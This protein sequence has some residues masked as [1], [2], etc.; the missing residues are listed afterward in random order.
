MFAKVALQFVALSSLLIEVI[1]TPVL[2]GRGS[3]NGLTRCGNSI[4]FNHWGGHASLDNLDHFYGV[5]NFDGLVH[6]SQVVEQE[7]Q[8]IC[9]TQVIEIIQQC[10]VVLQEMAKRIITEQIC[11]VR[12]QTIGMA[13]AAVASAAP[14]IMPIPDTAGAGVVGVTI[15][16]DA[17]D[18]ASGD[19]GTTGE[20]L[21]V[22]AGGTIR[23]GTRQRVMALEPHA[24]PSLPGQH[25]RTEDALV[26]AGLR[27]GGAARNI[28]PNGVRMWMNEMG[29]SFCSRRRGDWWSQRMH[30]R[31]DHASNTLHRRHEA[32]R[33]CLPPHHRRDTDSGPT[34]EDTTS[35][36]VTIVIDVEYDGSYKVPP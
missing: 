15:I 6:F 16:G 11:E 9:C 33:P 36:P 19:I 25:D 32:H 5:D 8:V 10:L 17:A 22:T 27:I 35:P 18:T 28:G 24:R 4:S 26:F 30:F 14:G 29:P 12:T 21:T 7:S 3:S 31:L 13:V 20:G 1:S 23:A 34:H 2:Y